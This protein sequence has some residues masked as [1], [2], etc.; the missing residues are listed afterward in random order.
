MS[1]HPSLTHSQVLEELLSPMGTLILIH[2]NPDA[3]AI[4]SAM[5]LSGLLQQLGSPAHCLC[6]D[7][8]P[9][10][11]RFLIDGLQDSLLP[12]N[13]PAELAVRRIITLDCA[14]P[15][16]LGTLW[17]TYGEHISIMIDHHAV[18]ERY[19]KGLIDPSCAATGEILYDLFRPL[20]EDGHISFD[21]QIASALYAAISADTGGFRFSN[22]TPETHLRAAALL[23][24]GIDAAYINRS[25]FEVKSMD[26]LRAHAA[27]ISNIRL[28]AD[29]RIAVL[30]FP[31]ALKIAL[32]LADEHLDAL[33]DI[34]RSLEGVQLAI[35][36]RQKGTE[37]IYRVSVR[38]ECD[39]D[40]SALC[41]SFGGGGHRKAAG[42]TITA[43]DMDSAVEKL[44]AVV[45]FLELS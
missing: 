36:I 3:D 35:A 25:L 4:G 37:G 38:S 7:E 22:T 26:R 30:T 28:Y 27:G 5:A 15:S 11:L 33:V 39:Y 20:E 17:E 2:H 12:E 16:Q 44:L 18:G 24:Y 8:C 32:G 19:A 34:P 21:R 6:A 29:G 40:V 31:Y 10:R 1:E 42:C 43:P 23:S 13:I 9:S 41:A 14:S 45:D